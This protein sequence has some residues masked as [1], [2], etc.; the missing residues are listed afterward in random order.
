M[1]TRLVY[2]QFAFFLKDIIERPDIKFDDLNSKLLN[3]FNG[4]PTQIPI[5]KELPADVVMT[6]LRSEGNEFTC[7]LAR[8]RVDFIYQRVTDD[9]TNSEILN[10]FKLKVAGLTSYILSKQEVARFGMV[11]R[12]FHQD[13]TA[14][15]TL[16]KK[17]FTSDVDEARELSLRYRKKAE[18]HGFQLNDIVE[19]SSS[20][21]LANKIWLKGI[22][23]QRDI[24]NNQ[25]A[26]E[27]LKLNVLDEIS[28]KFSPRLAESAI[29]A[30]IK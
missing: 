12:Y 2:L 8:S 26:G 16:R 19:I 25:K 11:A 9:K 14:V 15:R 7:N 17:Y 4:I 27:N 3:I 21:M 10:D 5:P 30:L 29:E 6:T 22:L 23:V 13:S 1:K 18:S 24:N 20:E 28:K